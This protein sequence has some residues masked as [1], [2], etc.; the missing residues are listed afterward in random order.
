MPFDNPHLT[1]IGDLEL[2]I[3]A[4]SRISSQASWVQGHFKDGDRH[5]LVAALSLA[6]GSQS[7]DRPSQTE[8]RL[9]RML[10]KRLPPAAVFFE[11]F[12]P[13]RHRLIMFNNDHHTSHDDVMALFDRTILHLTS[14][15]Q[16]ASTCVAKT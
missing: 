9:A 1:P 7:L 16:H 4:R 11:R 13:A 5:C 6:S 3:D 2:V 15:G 14:Q 10:A 12:L 8:R